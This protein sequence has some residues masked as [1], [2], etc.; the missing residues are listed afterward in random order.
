MS[1]P[2]QILEKYKEFLSTVVSFGQADGFVSIN[3]E[4]G[5]V[6]TNSSIPS[7]WRIDPPDHFLLVH[8]DGHLEEI[9]KALDREDKQD[10]E[11]Q[12][13]ISRL[14]RE[15][16]PDLEEIRRLD[17]PATTKHWVVNCRA[18][19]V[20]VDSKLQVRHCFWTICVSENLELALQ[21][22][23]SLWEKES[24]LPDKQKNKYRTSHKKTLKLLLA[25]M[26]EDYTLNPLVETLAELNTDRILGH[27]P[28]CTGDKFSNLNRF[29]TSIDKVSAWKIFKQVEELESQA[30]EI[31]KTL[32]P[33]LQDKRFKEYYKQEKKLKME[34]RSKVKSKKY[35]TL[36][37]LRSYF[38][39]RSKMYK[40]F[41]DSLKND[42]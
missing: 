33:V 36:D 8:T 42:S 9:Q 30:K 5:L 31:K 32:G 19:G 12:K 16:N 18:G 6:F 35:S 15:K 2:T 28:S 11:N 14:L 17:S 24:L 4:E 39:L 41:L 3:L 23:V 34:R 29:I 38:K 22:T 25:K 10:R 37:D 27:K 20:C 40:T 1:D 26:H 21:Q 13:K 7:W